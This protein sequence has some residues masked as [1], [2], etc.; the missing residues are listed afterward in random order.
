[1]NT[2]TTIL[3]GLVK[4]KRQAQIEQWNVEYRVRWAWYRDFFL[5]LVVGFCLMAA[6]TILFVYLNR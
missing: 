1:M 6:E 3:K 4:R 5:G 2:L